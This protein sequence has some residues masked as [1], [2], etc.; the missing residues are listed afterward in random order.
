MDLLIFI[1]VINSLEKAEIMM[2]TLCGDGKLLFEE[3]IQDN[4]VQ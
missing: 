1:Y 3:A 4:K 2:T